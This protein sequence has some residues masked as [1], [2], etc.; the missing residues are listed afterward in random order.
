MSPKYLN[1]EQNLT[2]K[3]FE[4]QTGFPSVLPEGQVF[5]MIVWDKSDDDSEHNFIDDILE[6]DKIVVLRGIFNGRRW[7]WLRDGE[8]V[9][10]EISGALL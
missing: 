2:V 4:D 1:L 6:T 5:R 9:T 8:K 10:V 3:R 7:A